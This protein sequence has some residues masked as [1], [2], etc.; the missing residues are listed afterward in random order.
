VRAS[1]E[2]TFAWW[3]DL[4]ED[5]AG[6]VMPPLRQRTIVRRTAEETVTEDRWSIFGIPM[7]TR[8]TLRPHPPDSWEVTTELRGGVGKDAVRLTRL[9]DGTRVAM[10]LDMDLRWP[11]SWAGRLLRPFL[12][13]LFQ[14]DLDAVNRTLDESRRRA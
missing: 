11:W 9:P 5:D 6:R 10:V 4:R 7:R 8:A 14:E 3:T 2:E 1:L 13:L 12:A